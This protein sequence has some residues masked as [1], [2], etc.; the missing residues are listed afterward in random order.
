MRKNNI[1]ISIFLSI[2][3]LSFILR[4][5]QDPLQLLDNIADMIEL[6]GNEVPGNDE[7]I[8]EVDLVNLNPVQEVKKDDKFSSFN[9]P[10]A[11]N[12]LFFPKSSDYALLYNYSLR[13]PVII[14]DGEKTVAP[15]VEP[16][17]DPDNPFQFEDPTLSEPEEPEPIEPL[18]IPNLFLNTLIFEDTDN[19][20]IWIND[21]RITNFDDRK[22]PEFYLTK[23]KDDYVELAI[24]S[25]DFYYFK[26][27]FARFLDKNEEGSD[28]DYQSANNN[29]FVNIEQ[30]LILVILETA[31]AFE[32]S[33]LIVLEQFY[34]LTS[35]QPIQPTIKFREPDDQFSFDDQ[36]F[37]LN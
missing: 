21:K 14:S 20:S 35:P 5:Q 12:D 17:F 16:E 32:G 10:K 28:W 29:V 18:I 26:G 3:M 1:K 13:N 4:A 9:I 8:K 34:E 37:P 7:G 19:W 6:N 15:V 33:T 2:F 27:F 25:R 11:E 24:K 30:N 23:I 22:Q 31:Q 36:N